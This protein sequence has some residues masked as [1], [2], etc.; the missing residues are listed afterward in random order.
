MSKHN[1]D[2]SRTY[3]RAD[4]RNT[5]LFIIFMSMGPLNRYKFHCRN[6]PES[7]SLFMLIDGIH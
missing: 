1:A 4:Q 7:I 3:T 2:V 5:I 6:L